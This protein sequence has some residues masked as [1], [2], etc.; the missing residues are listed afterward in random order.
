[1]NGYLGIDIGSISTKGVKVEKK[2][3]NKATQK[4]FKK[5]KFFG[6]S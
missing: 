3:L 4:K 1:M 6:L 5:Q 2:Q